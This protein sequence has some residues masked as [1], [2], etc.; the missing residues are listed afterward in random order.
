[1]TIIIAPLAKSIYKDV[2]DDGY[3]KVFDKLSEDLATQSNWFVRK[4]YF[5]TALEALEQVVIEETV[6]HG[7]PDDIPRMDFV[8]IAPFFVGGILEKLGET[9]IKSIEQVAFY[10]LSGHQEHQD[11]ADKWLQ[12]DRKR[13]KVFKKFI[14]ANRYYRDLIKDGTQIG[15]WNTDD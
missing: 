14:K 15:D 13:E 10:I 5:L 8:N 6:R 2:Q 12:V 1:M 9:K 4:K 3:R 11:A 7:E